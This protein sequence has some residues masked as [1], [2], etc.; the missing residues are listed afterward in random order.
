MALARI[1]CGALGLCGCAAELPQ[2]PDSVAD[3]VA[4]SSNDPGRACC[5]LES[6]EV[7]ARHEDSSSLAALRLYAWRRDANYVMLDSFAVLDEG[8]AEMVLLRGRL[9]RCPPLVR[10]Q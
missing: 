2:L 9:Y 6:V 10:L 3:S 8:D 1:V 4:L 5:P 7:R